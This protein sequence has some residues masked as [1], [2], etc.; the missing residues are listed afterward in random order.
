MVI[1]SHSVPCRYRMFLLCIMEPCVNVF[2]SFL[3]CP[4]VFLSEKH[5]ISL[6]VCILGQPKETER[7]PPVFPLLFHEKGA[8]KR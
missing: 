7:L 1:F 8:L 5:D 2:F 3:T 4:S 6:S